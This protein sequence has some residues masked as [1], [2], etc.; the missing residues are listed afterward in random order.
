MMSLSACADGHSLFSKYFVV[1]VAAAAI[2]KPGDTIG[3]SF[4]YRYDS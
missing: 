4:F 2:P 1:N 3:N